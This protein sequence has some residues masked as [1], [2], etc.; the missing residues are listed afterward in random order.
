MPQKSNLKFEQV[1]E[2]ITECISKFGGQP[3]WISEPEWPLDSQE[4]EKM[5][6]VGQIELNDKLF[7]DTIGKMAYI[8]INE[9][10]EGQGTWEPDSG[11]NAV[12]IQPG[13][14]KIKTVP[15]STGPT[16]PVNDY[17]VDCEV[18]QEGLVEFKVLYDFLEEPEYLN[19]EQIGALIDKDED[20]YDTYAEKMEIS[21][22]GG[23]PFFYSIRRDSY[24]RGM[25]ISV[26]A[27]PRVSSNLG[28][29]RYRCSLL[30]YR[31][32]RYVWKII[33]AVLKVNKA[34]NRTEVSPL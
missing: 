20:A 7:G 8:F 32:E 10:E 1:K 3:N 11:L 19:E 30:V 21:K 23:N 18:D 34:I 22:I 31:R 13:N 28:K 14:N 5:L 2:P 9:D 6:F 25:E 17:P 26:P 12:I 24:S 27:T 4:N 16:C 29:F 15:D 33:V